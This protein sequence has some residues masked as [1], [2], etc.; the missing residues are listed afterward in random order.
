MLSLLQ[1]YVLGSNKV[2]KMFTESTWTLEVTCFAGNLSLTPLRKRSLKHIEV[3]GLQPDTTPCETA[4]LH[5]YPSMISLHFDEGA[6]AKMEKERV[7][8][9]IWHWLMKMFM[10]FYR[11]NRFQQCSQRKG[12]KELYQRKHTITIFKLVVTYFL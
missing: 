3:Q 9:I 2:P 12:S 8:K 7:L 1:V 10:L 4:S 6:L 5:S 11:S